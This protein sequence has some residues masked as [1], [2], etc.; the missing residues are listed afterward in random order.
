MAIFASAPKAV[1]WKENN[2]ESM[3]RSAAGAPLWAENSNQAAVDM[4]S[5]LTLEGD[6]AAIA[7]FA[8]NGISNRP[9]TYYP[10]NF[11][12]AAS[13]DINA[14]GLSA[15]ATAMGWYTRNATT[16]DASTTARAA[17]RRRGG[18]AGGAGARAP[19]PFPFI[20]VTPSDRPLGKLLAKPQP[21]CGMGAGRVED[22][23]SLAACVC[24]FRLV[25]DADRSK[26]PDMW[27]AADMWKLHYDGFYPPPNP[28]VAPVG[29]G[30]TALPPG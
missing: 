17:S 5:R 14:R 4:L 16:H 25:V 27:E 26:A 1:L 12:R 10:M 22:A 30:A 15:V 6:P 3:L 9:G 21:I 29:S 28:R 19:E 7:A 8:A 11:A 24:Q 20:W 23:R 2:L 13:H 18:A